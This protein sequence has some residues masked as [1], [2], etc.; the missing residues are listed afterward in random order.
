MGIGCTGS[1]T[2][3]CMGDDSDTSL[4][5]ATGSHACTV[6]VYRESCKE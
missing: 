2:G 5:D 6:W 4:G 1:Y 3:L